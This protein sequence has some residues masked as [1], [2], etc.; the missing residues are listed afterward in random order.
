[1]TDIETAVRDLGGL[2]LPLELKPLEVAGQGRRSITFRADYQG[3]VVAMKVYRPAFI[4]KYRRKYDVNIAD[5]EISRNRAFRKIPE[6][7][8]F[9]ARPLAVMGLDGECSLMFLQEFVEGMVLA[10]LAEKNKGLPESVLEAGKTIVRVAELNGL[11][12][13]DIFYKNVLVRED[14]GVWLPVVHDF[15]QMPQDRHPPNPFLALAIKTGLRKRSHRDY[16]C[17]R[18]WHSYSEQCAST[19]G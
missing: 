16:R 14:S 3:E 1:L 12:D 19:S 2:N 9:A 4:E 8:P 17:L 7:L 10:E 15:N 18:E 6:L 13:L 11:H 5:F